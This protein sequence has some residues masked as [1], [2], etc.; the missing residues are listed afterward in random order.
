M[1]RSEDGTGPVELPIRVLIVDDHPVFRMGMTALLTSLDGIE[2]VGEAD[3]ADGAVASA[4]EL[5]VDVAMV[6]INLGATSGIDATRLLSAE[7]PDLAVL[8]VTMHDDQ[9]TVVAAIRA[10]ARGYVVKGASPDAV[11]RAVRAVA[12]GELI[13]SPEVAAAAAGQLTARR[14]SPFSGLTDREL[15]VL[16]LVAR[17]LD[18]QAIAQRLFLSPK[19]VRNHVSNLFTK[20]QVQDRPRAIVKARE[21]GLGGES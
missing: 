1:S 21:A 3:S 6:D 17:G 9:D 16:D 7:L 4:H 19:T 14:S 18:N 20:L 13:L 5:A 12:H 2:V 8:V 11:E 15:E 10:G